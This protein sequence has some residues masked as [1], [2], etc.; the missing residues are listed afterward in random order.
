MSFYRTYRPQIIEDIDNASVRERLAALLRKDKKSLPHAYLFTGPKGAGKTTA[1]RVIAK[2]FNCIKPAKQGP[3]GTCDQCLAIAKGTSLDVIEMDAASN[4]GIDE[5]R[6]LRDRIGLAPTSSAYTI[7]IID[8]VHM[9]TAEAFNALL[10]TLE[11]PPVHAVFILATTDREKVPDT[12][13]S[14]C[15]TITF[16]KALPEELMHALVRITT[17]EHIDISD[18]ALLRIAHVADGSFRDAVK[19]L[20]QVS[21]AKGKITE[22]MVGKTLAL[23]D[24]KCRESFLHHVVSKNT[25]ACLEDIAQAV[26][27]GRDMKA[28]LTDILADLEEKLVAS[29]MGSVQGAWTIDALREAIDRFTRAF[30]ELRISPIAQLPVELAVVELCHVFEN[31]HNQGEP[32]SESKNKTA[33]TKAPAVSRQAQ[34]VRTSKAP[35]VPDSAVHKKESFGL[36]TLEKLIEHWPDFISSTKPYNHSVSG[37]LRSS[38][39]KAVEDGIVVIE[40]FYKFHQEKLSEIKTKQI[41]EDVLKKLFGEKVQVQIV[42]G[43]K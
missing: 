41:L 35:I 38:R 39:P 1:A 19:Y 17:E 43:K 15:I 20:E 25:N 23:S 6:Q 31:V 16:G 32:A 37:V 24:A 13:Q 36:V 12:I 29:A 21:F 30:G 9:L 2:L 5:I 8:E 10:K 42:L 34:D 27:D 40:A 22:E 7:Y 11:E 3:C 28:F 33:G 4:R 14:R 18:T 26:S